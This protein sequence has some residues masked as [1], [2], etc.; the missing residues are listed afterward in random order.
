M[1]TRTFLAVV[2]VSAGAACSTAPS[3]SVYRLGVGDKSGGL[4]G[5]P[6]KVRR[7]SQDTY[8]GI[9][10]G[11][12]VVRGAEDWRNVWQDGHEP[13][14]PATLD[15]SS[16]MLLLAVPES[17]DAV[18][19]KMTKVLESTGFVH[20]WVRET[21]RGEGCIAR[22]GERPAHEAIFVPRMEK[23]VKFYVE[24]A[25]AEA[26]GEPPSP[27]V[28]CR[29]GDSKD[30]TTKVE[31]QP[32]D[33]V[34]CALTVETRGKFAVVDRSLLMSDVPAGS[35]AKLAY[36]K[37]PVRAKFRVDVFGTY[38]I[39]GE[40][41]DESGRKGA[42][43]VEVISAPAKTKD[44]VI[45]LVWTGFDVSDDPD[46]FPRLTLAAHPGT[47][48]CSLDKQPPDLCE[49]KRFSAYTVMRLKASDEKVPISVR[50][51]DERIEK[52]P[53]AC[54]QVWYDGARTAE[55]CDRKHRDPDERWD[56]GLVDMTTGKLVEGQPAAADAGV[57][58]GAPPPK[59]KR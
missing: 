4:Q 29:T 37:G 38:A 19:V 47:R 52:G 30:W 23:P 54:V 3:V 14:M 18:D 48:E 55:L 10:S 2:A 50:Y 35:T 9:R 49:V 41:T 42:A 53:L 31:A 21:M 43:Q 20:V 40:A 34:D 28:R 11:Y 51:V 45:Q 56:L 5:D 26:C 15:T 33:V 27:V 57:E 25:R 22:E 24:E 16:S 58:A 46:T 8:A 39:R 6:V 7:P 12:F 13:P 17:K 32:G 36:E 1:R 59:K 44:A